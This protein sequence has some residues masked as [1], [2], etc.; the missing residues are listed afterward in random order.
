MHLAL[1]LGASPHSSSIFV[2]E[3]TI[4]KCAATIATSINNLK[5]FVMEELRGIAQRSLESD[6]PT[7]YC[8]LFLHPSCNSLMT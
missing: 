4:R 2:N 7:S 8:V 5:N 3:M 6:L 1:V